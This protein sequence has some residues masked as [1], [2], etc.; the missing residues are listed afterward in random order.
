MWALQCAAKPCPGN[1]T[2]VCGAPGRLLAFRVDSCGAVPLPFPYCDSSLPRAA[3]VA[4]LISRLPLDTKTQCLED[5]NCTALAAYG[6]PLMATLYGEALHGL[7]RPC[8]TDLQGPDR[9]ATSFPHAQLLAAAFNRSLVTAVATAIGREARGFFNAYARGLAPN[10]WYAMSFM[11]RS[12]PRW[13]R[14]GV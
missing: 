9:C 6:L 7:R 11:V 1:S 5:N 12:D 4:D 8:A 14:D 13:G 2:E 3:R 10:A